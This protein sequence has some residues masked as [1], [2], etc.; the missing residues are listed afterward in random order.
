MDRL[1]SGIKYPGTPELYSKAIAPG[2][3]VF[4][5]GMLGIDP[6]TG[7]ATQSVAAQAEQSLLNLPGTLSESGSS[8]RQLV[9]TAIHYV[10]AED[11]AAINEVYTRHMPVPPPTRSAVPCSASPGGLLFRVDAVATVG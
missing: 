10:S 6:V 8:M 5:S 9:K 1:M 11:S 3:L 7:K 2:G 4:C